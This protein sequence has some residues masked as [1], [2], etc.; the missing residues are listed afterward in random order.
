MYLEDENANS[1]QAEKTITDSQQHRVLVVDDNEA[2][3][4]DIREALKKSDFLVDAVDTGGKAESLLKSNDYDVMLLDR[5]LNEKN[6]MTQYDRGE[7]FI[8]HLDELGLRKM[9]IL[10]VSSY[11][12]S[13]HI[14]KKLKKIGITNYL[15]KEKLFKANL[16]EVLI[17]K[18]NATISNWDPHPGSDYVS[19]RNH[20]LYLDTHIFEID[21][22]VKFS[23]TKTELEIVKLF[24]ENPTVVHP[25]EQIFKIVWKISDI[26]RDYDYR[27]KVRAHIGNVNRKYKTALGQD[28]GLMEHRGSGYILTFMESEFFG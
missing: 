16:A 27:N 4:E 12:E 21:G 3:R 25:T 10:I 26:P 22:E 11:L 19:F 5:Q 24:I 13:E 1:A 14:V 9:P 28:E 15:E 8:E 20:G 7:D 23:V 6:T 17:P 18:V 2:W